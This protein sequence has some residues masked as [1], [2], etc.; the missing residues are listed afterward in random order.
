MC[1]LPS[2]AI[3]SRENFNYTQQYLKELGKE[4]KNL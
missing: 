2:K 3:C 4:K 1:E